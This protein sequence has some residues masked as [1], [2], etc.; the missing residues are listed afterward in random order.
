MSDD[1]WRAAPR[2]TF[3]V[4]DQVAEDPPTYHYGMIS[5]DSGPSQG[6]SLVTPHPPAVGD[7]IGL[8]DRLTRTSGGYRVIERY[9]TYSQYGSGDWPAGEMHPRTGP[10]LTLIVVP[11][12]GPFRDETPLPPE[13]EEG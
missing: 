12:N 2:C 10:L 9:W 4:R 1:I 8:H 11:D 7:L 5:Q 6:G 13:E 3:Y